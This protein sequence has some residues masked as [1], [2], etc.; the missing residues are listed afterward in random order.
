MGDIISFDEVKLYHEYKEFIKTKEG[1]EWKE[2][3]KLAK[4]Y[5][6]AGDFGTYLFD[7]HAELFV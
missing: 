3:W 4:G 2:Q 6:K 5:E 1:K 7:F